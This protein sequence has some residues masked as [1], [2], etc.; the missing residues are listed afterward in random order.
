MVGES[1]AEM[2]PF[3]LDITRWSYRGTKK[4]RGRQFFNFWFGQPPEQM[5]HKP[6]E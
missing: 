1:L 3:N 5:V 6:D 4:Q 2:E